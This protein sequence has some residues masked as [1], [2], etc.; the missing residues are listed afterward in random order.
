MGIVI[1]NIVLMVQRYDRSIIIVIAIVICIII[2]IIIVISFKTDAHNN[3]NGHILSCLN[4]CNMC[5]GK[6]IVIDSG[7]L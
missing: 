5:G 1:L 2:T 6:Y 4:D 3:R 7:R